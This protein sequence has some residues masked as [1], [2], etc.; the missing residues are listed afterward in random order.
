MTYVSPVCLAS[1][2]IAFPDTGS[3]RRHAAVWGIIRAVAP[4]AAPG[5]PA[6]RAP[7][8]SGGLVTAGSLSPLVQLLDA[9][10][11]EVILWET[12]ASVNMECS[13]NFTL[14]LV[15]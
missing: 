9:G 7:A 4:V 14:F 2:P 5:E 15:F 10:E 12:G 8:V 3:R 11:P 6:C 13:E 1:M